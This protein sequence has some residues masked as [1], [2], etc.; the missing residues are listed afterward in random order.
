VA[1]C[2]HTTPNPVQL[3]QVGDDTMSCRTIENQMQDMQNQI[4]ESDSDGNGQIAKNVGLGVAGALLIVPWFFMDTSDAHSV[5]GKAAAARYKRLSAL[6]E[7]KGCVPAGAKKAA[8]SVSPDAQG[9]A[10][11]TAPLA[12]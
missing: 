11:A 12:Q 7:D 8:V 1:A 3:S 10:A 5:E 6:Y 2:V 4:H 9:Q